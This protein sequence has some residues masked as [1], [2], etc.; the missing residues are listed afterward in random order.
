[1][2][3][4]LDILSAKTMPPLRYLKEAR[5]NSVLVKLKD[6]GEYIGILDFSDNTMNLIL[7]D[8]VELKENTGELKAKHGTILI[9][10]SNILFVSL[11]YTG[12]G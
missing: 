10:G 3:R 11:N 7:K 8:C 5:G 12:E 1:M 4:R 2:L 6:G 9:R